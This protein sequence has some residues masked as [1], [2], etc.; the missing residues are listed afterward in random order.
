MT[1][2]R[3]ARTC[4]SAL[5]AT[6]VFAAAA[7]HEIPD[8]VRV[9][10][11]L[12][13][14]HE[15][16]LDHL[17]EPARSAILHFFDLAQPLADRFV[18]AVQAHDYAGAH[19]LIGA[20]LKLVMSEAQLGQ[21]LDGFESDVGGVRGYA[22][23]TQSYSPSRCGK[24]ELGD[25]VVKMYAISEMS[26]LSPGWFLAID[27]SR[28]NNR[29]VVSEFQQVSFGLDVPTWLRPKASNRTVPSN[30]RLKLAARGRPV[31]E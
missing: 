29:L 9:A 17:S 1:T 30:N 23:R 7:T 16:Q 26:H 20:D 13:A 31:A 24:G 28:E 15:D 10:A 14:I 3:W 11:E 18:R 19:R 27:I 22:F 4:I 5:A 8:A 21:R 2:P 12:K 6:V 25:R